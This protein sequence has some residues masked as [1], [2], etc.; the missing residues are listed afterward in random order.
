MP[1]NV[2]S[3]Q[4]TSQPSLSPTIVEL[5]TLEIKDHIIIILVVTYPLIL[6]SFI[7]FSN[8]KHSLFE[9][10]W[11][12]ADFA[13]NL[14]A[15][16]TDILF[17]LQLNFIVDQAKQKLKHGDN[18][19]A[20]E[21]HDVNIFFIVSI[22]IMVFVALVNFISL[23]KLGSFQIY[24]FLDG[25]QTLGCFGEFVLDYITKPLIKATVWW[26]S[27]ETPCYV[28]P[29]GPFII[30]VNALLFVFSFI[31]MLIGTYLILIYVFI[32]QNILSPVILFLT[33]ISHSE[34]TYI[35]YGKE[36]NKFIMTLAGLLVEDILEFV[37]QVTYAVISYKK[38]HRQVTNIQILSF[39]FTI[40]RLMFVV[41]LKIREEMRRL[42]SN[43]A[44]AIPSGI[45]DTRIVEI[46]QEVQSN[47]DVNRV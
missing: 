39:A 31:F 10:L 13:I 6:G 22:V 1:T 12:I 26:F 7:L 45:P 33:A 19:A 42:E 8:Q 38:Y 37:L 23:L 41:Y 20:S 4:P 2:P 32:I 15:S 9:K 16:V 5:N 24:S 46:Y 18:S 40:Y 35:L 21:V 43:N 11:N 36:E 14:G 34:L 30:T 44:I 47:E 3:D 28:L 29:F 27:K 17:T 25:K